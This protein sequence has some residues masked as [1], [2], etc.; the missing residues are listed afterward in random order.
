MSN[1]MESNLKFSTSWTQYINNSTSTTVYQQQYIIITVKLNQ[2]S[3]NDQ[4]WRVAWI[5]NVSKL[6]VIKL[7]PIKSMDVIILFVIKIYECNESF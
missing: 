6:L 7:Y 3:A 5:I 2:E 4:K 1:G